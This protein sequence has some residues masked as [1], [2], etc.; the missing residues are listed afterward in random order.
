MGLQE[1]LNA[2]RNYC[3]NKRRTKFIIIR[4]GLILYVSDKLRLRMN[5]QE[6]DIESVES[7]GSFVA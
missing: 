2:L 3:F 7:L 6:G 4:M 1:N 5:S